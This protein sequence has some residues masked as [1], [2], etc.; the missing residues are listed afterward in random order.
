MSLI[1]GKIKTNGFFI[2]TILVAAI[3]VS[4]CSVTPRDT[5]DLSINDKL[6]DASAHKKNL[7]I[8]V[9]R[10]QAVKVYDGQD[11]V[12]RNGDAIAYLDKAQWSDRLPE[13]VQARLTQTLDNTGRFAGIGRPG[14]GLSINYQILTNIRLFDIDVTNGQKTAKVEI[15][16][17]IMDD[18]TGNIRASRVFSSQQAVLGTNNAEYAKALNATFEKLTI[19]IV[20]WTISSL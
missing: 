16:A 10:P 11:I 13:L 19:D 17:K 12:I 3:A 15:S 4:S 2:I 6:N 20:N 1:M 5:F 14:D 8:M 9:T 7:Q 18:K